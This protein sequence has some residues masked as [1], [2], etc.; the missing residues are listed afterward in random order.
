[1][2]KHCEERMGRKTNSV[3]KEEEAEEEVE[4]EEIAGGRE[5]AG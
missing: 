1:M 2:T 3:H 5:G 4:E